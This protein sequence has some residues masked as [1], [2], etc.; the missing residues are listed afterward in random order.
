M[1]VS[2]GVL[3]R[4]IDKDWYGRILAQLSGATIVSLVP[5][6]YFPLVD[7]R[8]NKFYESLERFYCIQNEEQE[9]PSIH[10]YLP[11]K[12]DVVDNVGYLALT[13]LGM[14]SFY[15]ATVRMYLVRLDSY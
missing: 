3:G 10:Y 9:D 14:I 15:S 2:I 12:T 6:S 11:P 7:G 13:I 5:L 8:A 4:G 1:V